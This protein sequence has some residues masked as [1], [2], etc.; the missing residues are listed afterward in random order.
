MLIEPALQL[1]RG[2]E[3]A[4]DRPNYNL[5]LGKRDRPRD[6]IPSLLNVRRCMSPKRERQ[7][8]EETIRVY[9]NCFI[10][11]APSTFVPRAR[12]SHRRFLVA[13]LAIIYRYNSI[14]L[15]SYVVINIVALRCLVNYILLCVSHFAE[16]HYILIHDYMK[17]DTRIHA[18]STHTHIHTHTYTHT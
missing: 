8:K 10:I 5:N 14:S 11:T 2:T 12:N 3:F 13:T 15:W 6:R 18:H 16:S 9:F 1:A 4:D 17:T 7:K